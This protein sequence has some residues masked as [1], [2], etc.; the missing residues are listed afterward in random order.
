MVVADNRYIAED[1]ASLVDGGLRAAARR[2]RCA[3]RARAR[4][5][6]RARDM[7]PTTSLAEF[8][9]GY[10]DV[11]AAFAGAAHCRSRA[12]IQ[13]RGGG[14]SIECRGVR[15]ELRQA[16]ATSSRSGARRRRRTSI[17]RSLDTA[18]ARP[19]PGARGRARRRRR[20]RPQGSCS[21]RRSARGRLAALAAR[22]AGEMDRGPAR[23]LPRRP[24]RSATS[25]GT[26]RSRSTRDG[27]MLGAAR[28]ARARQRRLLPCAASCCRS[29]A[30]DHG[31]GPYV[32]PAFALD[33]TSRS[34]TR[35]RPRRCAAPAGRRPCSSWSAAWTASRASWSSTAPRC[36]GAT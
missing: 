36:A 6:A 25:T 16:L 31:A 33:V 21:I 9:L 17:A 4:R 7:R 1:A 35:C 14:H 18:A 15:R 5:A 28:H 22:P 3:R 27:E 12:L 23:A 2:G 11:D 19:R 24:R 32:V 13:H 20:L 29:I 34:P 26:S 8:T 10:G 30:G